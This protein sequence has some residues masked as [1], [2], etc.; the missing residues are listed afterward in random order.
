LKGEDL[1]QARAVAALGFSY[2]ANPSFLV[3]GDVSVNS[4][5][6]SGIFVMSSTFSICLSL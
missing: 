2:G 5:S 6:E 1:D 4:G 3:D